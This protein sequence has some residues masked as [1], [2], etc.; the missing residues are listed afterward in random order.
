MALERQGRR[1][2]P[3]HPALGAVR[4]RRHGR[5]GQ[6]GPDGA[7]QQR[8]GLLGAEAQVVL[9]QL[10]QLPAGPQPCQRQR[11]VGAACQHQPQ[12]RRPV[13]QQEPE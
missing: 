12:P 2:Q 10:G 1:L 4:Q 11:R 7:A 9:A 6:V 13:L 3:G 5:L 8:G